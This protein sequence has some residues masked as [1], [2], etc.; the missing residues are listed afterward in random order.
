M[1]A[2]RAICLLSGG[3]DSTTTLY[4]ARYEGYKVS[5]LTVHY[6]QLHEKEIACAR[7]IASL[8]GVS[9]HVV[10]LSLPWKGSALLDRN[11]PIPKGRDEKTMG[12]DIPATYVPARNSIL[13]ALAASWAEAQGASRIFLGANIQDYSGYPDC[14]PE[15]LARFSEMLYAGTRAGIQGER[16]EVEAPLLRLTKKNIILLG[17]ALGVPF[18]KTWSCYEGG[19]QPCGDCDSC[20]LRAKGF[21]EAGLVDPLMEHVASTIHT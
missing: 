15:F 14:R 21:R 3:L 6:G 10:S 19:A 12:E 1:E 20:R 5:A 9:H 2:K 17:Q 13:L 4:V 18:E 11:L 7:D 16:I 8:T